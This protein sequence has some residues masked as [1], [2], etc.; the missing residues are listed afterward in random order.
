MQGILRL[1]TSLRAS[2]WK[3]GDNCGPGMQGPS[4]WPTGWAPESLQDVPFRLLWETSGR[5]PQMAARGSPSPL[6]H[7]KPWMDGPP[8]EQED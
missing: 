2:S 6:S 1:L 5:E 8:A 3:T 4:S 7:P